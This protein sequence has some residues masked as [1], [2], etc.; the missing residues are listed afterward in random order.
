MDCLNHFR[1]SHAFEELKGMNQ[2]EQYLNEIKSVNDDDMYKNVL[3]YYL[4]NY[5]R[6]VMDRKERNRE[7]RKKFN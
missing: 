2:F 1:G 6:E 4:V 5:E 7:K 3:K